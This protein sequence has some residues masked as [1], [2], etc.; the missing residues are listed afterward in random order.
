MNMPTDCVYNNHDSQGI[1][2]P[3]GISI[4]LTFLTLILFVAMF[5]PVASAF[6]Q[7]QNLQPSEL[8]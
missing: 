8:Q 6:L 2:T 5:Q 7:V 3:H 4:K 1:M